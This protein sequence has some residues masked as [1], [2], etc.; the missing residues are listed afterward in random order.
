MHK[1]VNTKDKLLKASKVLFSKKSF[2]DITT[3]EIAD[4]AGVNLSAIKYYFSSKENLFIETIRTLFNELRTDYWE[5]MPDVDKIRT[6]EEAILNLKGFIKRFTE[7]MSLPRI[8]NPSKMM[9]RE[10]LAMNSKSKKMCDEMV[11]IITEE[12]LVPFHKNGN[13]L[14]ELIIP[15]ASLEYRRNVFHL[16]CSMCSHYLISG[17]FIKKLYGVEDVNVKVLNEFSNCIIDFTLS[18]LGVKS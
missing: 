7:L 17:E 10:V 16:I 18:A 3:R 6:K 15:D 12:F 9:C 13:K 1:K 4:K 11:K 14:M 2:S 8:P 5:F